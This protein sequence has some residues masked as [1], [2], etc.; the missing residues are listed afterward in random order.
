MEQTRID[1][2]L[3]LTFFILLGILVTM[4]IYSTVYNAGYDNGYNKGYKKGYINAL[5]KERV[6]YEI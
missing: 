6:N 1:N 2:I 5:A 4:I 3:K